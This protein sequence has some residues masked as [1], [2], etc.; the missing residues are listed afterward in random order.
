MMRRLMTVLLLAAAGCGD[1]DGAGA[2]GEAGAAKTEL[3]GDKGLL[4]DIHLGSGSSNPALFAELLGKAY[5]TATDSASGRELWV[6]DGTDALRRALDRLDA[7]GVRVLEAGL[8]RP[9]LD[10]VFLTLTGRP[11]EEAVPSEPEP[12]VTR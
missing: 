7:A 9:T 4:K 11:A 3:V 8:R 5:F 1:S 10:D 12:A 2:K 6:T